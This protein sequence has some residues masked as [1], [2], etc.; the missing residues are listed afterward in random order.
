MLQ[1]L[2]SKAVYTKT[3][4]VF[5]FLFC[6]AQICLFQRCLQVSLVLVLQEMQLSEADGHVLN[7]ASPSKTTDEVHKNKG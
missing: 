5:S 4:T 6:K 7:E 1:T 2:R 3:R